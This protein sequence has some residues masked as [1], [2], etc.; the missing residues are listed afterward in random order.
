MTDGGSEEVGL[1]LQVLRHEAAIART[2]TADLL[3]IYIWM[4]RTKALHT[5]DDVFGNTLSRRVDMSAGELLPEARSTAGVDDIDHIA[6][7]GIG[8]LRIAR[9]EVAARGR[10]ATV[11]VHNHR[12]FLRCIEVGRQVETAADSVAARRDEVPRQAVTQLDILEQ[13]LVRVVKEHCPLA[14]S[15]CTLSLQ[16]H[17]IAA[18]AMGGALT[19]ECHECG[20]AAQREAGDEFLRQVDSLY[21]TRLRI[22]AEEVDAVAVLCREVN[23][24]VGFAPA[25]SLYTG[26]ERAGKGGGLSRGDVEEEELYVGHTRDTSF[27]HV[28]AYAAKRLGRPADQQLATVGREGSA[29]EEAVVADKGIGTKGVQVQTDDGGKRGGALCQATAA[30]H[31]QQVSSVGRDISHADVVE[32][33]GELL[34]ETCL[35]VIQ[36][37]RRARTP[38]GLTVIGF[39]N[40]IDTIGTLRSFV[41][42]GEEQTVFV[43][44]D[45]ERVVGQRRS[46][47][48]LLMGGGINN[49]ESAATLALLGIIIA[50]GTR[51]P[52]DVLVG[53]KQ[54][55]ACLWLREHRATRS[56][57]T[58]QRLVIATDEIAAIGRQ[59]DRLYPRAVGNIAKRV[60][61]L[62]GSTNQRRGRILPVLRDHNHCRIAAT[63]LR[64]VF[65]DYLVIPRQQVKVPAIGFLPVDE[66][67]VVLQMTHRDG[68]LGIA[69]CLEVGLQETECLLAAT[70]RQQ[71]ISGLDCMADQIKLQR[72]IEQRSRL[73]ALSVEIHRVEHH[74]CMYLVGAGIAESGYSDVG[75]VYRHRQQTRG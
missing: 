53:L 26:V 18:V 62:A 39:A 64:K 3:L 28:L 45:A 7:G 32:A 10:T 17:Q 23:L 5:L 47:R 71:T 61:A 36:R 67:L 2:D 44:Q 60:E 49:D 33:I 66:E 4:L 70:L 37:Q 11:V 31:E 41:L 74:R 52:R 27:R 13:F 1:R 30:R 40:L 63:C 6:Q 25:G 15:L 46:Q 29:I 57:S 24:S 75:S 34:G 21:L 35:H 59:G 68:S 56:G 73:I 9:F 38:A 8:M 14:L 20:G 54:P 69:E 51:H 42:M 16:I 48:L 50:V 22:Q 19:R 12:I 65:H 72:S 43:G 58:R 55:L